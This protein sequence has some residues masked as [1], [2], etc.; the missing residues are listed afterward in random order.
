[1]PTGTYPPIFL[2]PLSLLSPQATPPLNPRPPTKAL[3]GTLI[4]DGLAAEAVVR[5]D[6][7]H[8]SRKPHDQRQ[9]REGL[10]SLPL[11]ARVAAAQTEARP[12]PRAAAALRVEVAH[13][14]AEGGGPAGCEEQIRAVGCDCR[15]CRDHPDDGEDNRQRGPDD[16]VDDAAE[17]ADAVAEALVQ[18]VGCQAEDDDCEDELRCAQDE[19]DQAG[20]DHGDGLVG[21]LVY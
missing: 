15:L 21:W 6:T 17:G 5:D 10:R 11:P 7:Q 16:G 19:G 1:M 3:S 9:E 18:E 12:R 20:D 4:D 2:T 8:K 13:Q 14:H